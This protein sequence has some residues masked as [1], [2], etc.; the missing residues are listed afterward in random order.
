MTH[1]FVAAQRL[2]A[3]R[4]HGAEEL[5]SKLLQKGHD[6]SEVEAVISECQRLGL[7]CDIRFAASFCRNR[8]RQGY[9]P[10]RIRQE[11][12]GKQI[13]AELIDKTL[14]DTEHDWPSSAQAVWLKKFKGQK[15]DDFAKMQ[16][17]KQFMYYRG[18]SPDII[19]Q[20]IGKL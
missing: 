1:A 7:Q 3:R 8:V 2:L 20:V 17:Q 18:F 11:L 14:C 9:G 6:A 12:Q 16:K 10:L 19:E 4:E 5:R 13:D 15:P